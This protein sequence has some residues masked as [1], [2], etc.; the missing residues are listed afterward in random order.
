[1]AKKKWN[2]GQINWN[3][4]VVANSTH[5]KTKSKQQ[6]MRTN[7][8]LLF[9]YGNMSQPKRTKIKIIQWLKSN[10]KI[11]PELEF[12]AKDDE[13]KNK[14]LMQIIEHTA[15]CSNVGGLDL[16]Q[17][18][19]TL[20]IES[21]P[22]RGYQREILERAKEK[23]V[24]CY[25]P[26][27][28]GKTRVAIGLILLV[29]QRTSAW[30]NDP[31]QKRTWV[32]FLVPT[33]NLATQQLNKIKVKKRGYTFFSEFSDTYKKKKLFDN[34]VVVQTTKLHTSINT[35]FQRKNLGGI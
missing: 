28:C 16:A 21:L 25:M 18:L 15:D 2:F 4:S 6:E 5:D 29:L 13:A 34:V 33:T 30:I 20:E 32:I 22:Q 11:H 9:K 1:S 12:L 24:I 7:V 27:G 17:V 23:N 31:Q 26:T 14:M 19:M 8:T 10:A 35:T 3:S